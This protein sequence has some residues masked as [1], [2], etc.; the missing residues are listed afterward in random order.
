MPLFT[1]VPSEPRWHRSARAAFTVLFFLVWLEA[2]SCFVFFMILSKNGSPIPTRELSESVFNHGHA[3]Y[4]AASQ[5]VL[6]DLL[7]TTMK[8]AIPGTMLAGF[9]LH[10]V[11]GV[12][13][14]SN[15]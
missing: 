1:T 7:L 10:Y 8:F 9:L 14:F 6:Y 12:K 3:F 13:I 4:V 2:V 15:R 11:V 5:K